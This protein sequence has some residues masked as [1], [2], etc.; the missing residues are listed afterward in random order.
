M[1]VLPGGQRL[2]RVLP[3]L[4]ELLDSPHNYLSE[5]PLAFGSRRMY[6]LAALFALPG[7]AFLLSCVLAK[8]DGERIAMGV[9]FLI[10]SCVWLGW[11]LML[12]GH[13]LVMHPDGVEVIFRDSAVWAPWALFHVEGQPFVP[14][15]DS[16]RAG[17]TMP[18]NPKAIPYVELR[19]GGMVIARGLHVEGR[20]WFF[21]GRSEVTLPGRYEIAAEDVGELLLWLGGQ[22]G[23]DLPREP[24]PAEAELDERIDLP[25]AD[26]E[27]WLTVPLTRLRLP[28]CCAACGGPRDDTLR[29]QVRARGDWL[30]GPFF[31]MRAAEVG[32]P[33][34][35]VCRDRI[36]REQRRGGLL[37]LVLGAFICSVLGF[38]LG[39]WLGELRQ[40]PL[41]LG[42]FAGLFVGTLGGSLIGVTLSRRLPIRFRRYSP[43][44]GLVSVRFTNP[45]IATRV[46]EQ[47][48][49][50]ARR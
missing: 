4:D 23:K 26:P 22:L 28:P 14:E 11:S 34:C 33:I 5:A 43:S 16:P 24:P 47:M 30:L 49:E 39:G 10:G 29:V 21:V 42:T 2:H 18:I 1:S 41:M 48:R 27:G 15:S 45:E 46:I 7:I 50:Q 38:A 32:V 19:R 20:Q 12:R 3:D 35:T 31:G 8:P 6:G 25:D 40:L 9:G 44:R 36:V 13:E 17:L 37:G